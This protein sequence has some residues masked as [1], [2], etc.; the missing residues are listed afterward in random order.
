[1]LCNFYLMQTV[2]TT[3]V[4]LNNSKKKDRIF[5]YLNLYENIFHFISL[6][7]PWKERNLCKYPSLKYFNM[8][9][10]KSCTKHDYCFPRLKAT[11]ISIL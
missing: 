11:N 3:Q 9:S 6:F 4:F 10:S 8:L 1:M 5:R 7:T 2:V